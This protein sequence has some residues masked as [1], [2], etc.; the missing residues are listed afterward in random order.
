MML[1]K[2]IS[3]EDLKAVV[4]VHNESFKDFFLTKLGSDFLTVYYDCIRKDTSAI[5][6][7][8]F[9]DNELCGFCAATSLSSGFNK[10][11][12]KENLNRFLMLGFKQM[13]TNPSSLIHLFKNLSKS[14]PNVSDDGQYAELLSIGISV[15][16]Q[17]LGLGKEL[18]KQLEIDLITKGIHNLSLTTDYY[19]NDKAIRFYKGLG[20]DIF[21]EFIAYPNRKMFR[22][23][24]KI[25]S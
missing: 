14:N 20:Y 23:I 1:V 11:L 9:I 10:R 24:K 25:Q 19:K 22:L 3:N 8:I 7:G 18:L 6:L 5:L 4:K 13:I 15:N 17:G 16:K 12:I 2:K 21:Y